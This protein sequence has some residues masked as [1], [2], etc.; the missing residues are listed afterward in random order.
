M[1]VKMKGFSS[2]L[3]KGL[4]G[5]GNDLPMWSQLRLLY[6]SWNLS[7][8]SVFYPSFTSFSDSERTTPS[9]YSDL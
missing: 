5:A 3:G 9:R 2:W 4:T 1:T 8:G 7:N 6:G